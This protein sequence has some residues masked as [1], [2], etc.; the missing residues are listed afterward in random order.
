MAKKQGETETPRSGSVEW[1]V[2][3]FNAEFIPLLRRYS[4]DMGSQVFFTED[5]RI[6]SK[7]LLVDVLKGATPVATPAESGLQ[8]A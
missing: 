2:K 5:G 1:R 6:A 7:P 3:Q 8:S 4:F